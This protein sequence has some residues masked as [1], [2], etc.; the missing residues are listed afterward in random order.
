MSK[1]L[2]Q[3]LRMVGRYYADQTIAK[4]LEAAAD[5][6]EA[7]AAPVGERDVAGYFCAPFMKGRFE[8]VDSSCAGDEDVFPLYR[9]PQ[10]SDWQPSGADYDRSIHSNPDAKAWADFF[11]ATFPG[12]ADKHDLMLG[13][14]ANAMMAMHDHLKAQ[15]PQSEY[16]DAYQGSREDLAIWKRRALEAESR[17]REQDQIIE[18]L[19]NALNAENGPT[20]MGEPVIQQPQSAEAVDGWKLVPVE[21]TPDMQQAALTSSRQSVSVG[22]ARTLTEGCELWAS[23]EVYKVMLAAAPSA[24]KCSTCRDV[25]VIGHSEIFPDCADTWEPAPKADDPVKVQSDDATRLD[26]MLIRNRKVVVE[27][28]PNDNFAVYVEEGFMGDKV[29][30]S[31]SYSGEWASGSSE[32]LELKRKAIDAAIAAARKGEG[33]V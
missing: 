23:A 27:R 19:G 12:L 10:P 9:K 29:Y 3:E 11:V 6:L 24:P 13:W 8:Q 26:F 21:P 1:E 18:N 4:L 17:I 15:Q 20:F 32:E 33:K 22:S 2:I 5:A 7:K 31:V 14:F 28:L 16:G 25:G 30:P